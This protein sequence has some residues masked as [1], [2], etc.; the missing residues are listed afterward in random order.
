MGVFIQVT[1]SLDW[2]VLGNLMV[3]QLVH[4]IIYFLYKVLSRVHWSQP[5]KDTAS[6]MKPIYR[7]KNHTF[8]INFNPGRQSMSEPPQQPLFFRSQCS[9]FMTLQDFSHLLC[10]LP[11]PSV[12][13]IFIILLPGEQN[14]RLSSFFPLKVRNICIIV[15]EDKE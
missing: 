5:V 9:P 1:Y 3:C 7:F 2:V 10:I 6:D 8:K 14:S 4:A 13:W 11:R 12:L 15:I